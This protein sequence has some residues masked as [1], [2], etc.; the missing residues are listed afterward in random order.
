MYFEQE[1]MIA[2][3]TLSISIGYFS[4]KNKISAE[5]SSIL[6]FRIF[7]I[8]DQFHIPTPFMTESAIRI[9]KP[10]RLCCKPVF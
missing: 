1:P 7:I 4:H 8:I 5:K 6:K 3:I 10:A 9:N 2:N